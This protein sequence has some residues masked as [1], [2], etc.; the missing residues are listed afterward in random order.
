[1]AETAVAEQTDDEQI[2]AFNAEVP[3]KAAWLPDKAWREKAR[4]FLT[5]AKS[6]GLLPTGIADDA[7]LLIILGGYQVGWTPLTALKRFYVVQGRLAMEAAGIAQLVH[8]K[9]LGGFEVLEATPEQATV[10][11]TN[12]ST[13]TT[14]TGTYTKADSVA[15][16]LWGKHEKNPRQQLLWKC[17]AWVLR[18]VYPE[19]LGFIEDRDD[20]DA[21]ATPFAVTHETVEP[22][23]GPPPRFVSTDAIL[24]AAEAAGLDYAQMAAELGKR[25][26][27]VDQ[28][29]ARYGEDLAAIFGPPVAKQPEP[30]A[31]EPETETDGPWRSKAETETPEPEPA[32]GQRDLFAND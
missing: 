7:A 23:Q 10:R 17:I 6:G 27:R 18:V 30:P 15:A 12:Q 16:G 25:G 29:P 22:Y 28:V 1:M 21:I 8:E 31:A 3:T 5:I 20:A 32:D 11:A 24:Q 19:H 4:T 13:G 26:W 2:Q 9:R 14:F